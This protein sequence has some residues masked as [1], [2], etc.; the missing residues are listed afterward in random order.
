MG[1]ILEAEP[2][3][4]SSRKQLTL[5]RTMLGI[6]PNPGQDVYFITPPF[7]PSVSIKNQQT[8]KTATIR[9]INFDSSYKNIYIQKATLNGKP[10][11]K[12]WLQHSFFLDGGTLELTLGSHESSWGTRVQDLPPSLSEYGG[13]AY[14]GDGYGGNGGGYGGGYGHGQ[15]S[16]ASAYGY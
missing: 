7:F 8:G 12:N 10:Y 3:R 15:P 4:T 11:T 5:D 9:N 13:T 14:G 2:L 1:C 6:F 16:H